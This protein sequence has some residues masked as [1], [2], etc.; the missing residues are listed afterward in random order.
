MDLSVVRFEILTMVNMKIAV[1]WY[2]MPCN[3]VDID[4]FEV[5]TA[6]I[7]RVP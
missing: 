4:L 5:S 3:P 2:V 1:I 7:I 6:S